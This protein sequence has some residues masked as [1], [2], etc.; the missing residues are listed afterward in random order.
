MVDYFNEAFMLS[1]KLLFIGLIS[2]P[3]VVPLF[4]TISYIFS[5]YTL[6]AFDRLS[7]GGFIDF[8][9]ESEEESEE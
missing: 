3:L 8:E 1:L 5:T 4:W 9:E 2:I 7:E 6:F